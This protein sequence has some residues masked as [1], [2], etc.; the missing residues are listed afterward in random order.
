MAIGGRFWSM[1]FLISTLLLF[2]GTVEAQSELPSLPE[3]QGSVWVVPIEGTI[4]PGLSEFVKRV[5][6]SARDHDVALL[7]FEIN[8]F[9]G[10][11]DSATEIR[12]VIVATD[13][14][15]AAYISER[16]ISAGALVALAADR[17]VMAPGATFGAAEPQ[18]RD[19]K[20]LSYVRAEFE[21]TAERAKRDPL[22]AAAMVDSSVAVEGLVEA[23]QILTLTTAKAIEYG[24]AD[25]TA[26]SR[27]DA[28]AVLGYAGASVVEQTPSWAEGAVRFLTDPLV[29]QILLVVGFLGLVAE[30]AAPG[31]G[32]PGTVG[33]IAFALFFGSRL[34]T[35]I[36]GVETIILFLLGIVLI[37]L[38]IFVIPGFGIAGLLGL[39]SMGASVFMSFPDPR[40]AL[41]ALAITAVAIVVLVLLF[42]KRFQK[43]ALWGRLVLTHEQK[44]EGYRPTQ[45]DY[46][47]LVGAEG[48]ADTQLR[49]AGRILVNGEYYDAVAD[50][51][52]IPHGA[53]VRVVK[54][55]GA[56]IVVRPVKSNQE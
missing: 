24:Y 1:A 40:T 19:E 43:S 39:V 11:V 3:I 38:E 13:I 25:H 42:L 4:D 2:G 54:V 28:L 17:V 37:L 45:V 6:R 34:I 30:F 9:G 8:T 47:S 21:A 32:V 22:I 36:L 16:A 18:P 50:G 55:E 26:A 23:G 35:G 33:L 48:V 53:P 15:T 27:S 44:E 12:D 49:P 29:A 51:T 46:Q 31:W 7:L 20:T 56:R 52:M 5:V 10:R 14:P 41:Q